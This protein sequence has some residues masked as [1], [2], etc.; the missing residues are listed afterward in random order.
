MDINK[1]LIRGDYIRYLGTSTSQ[2]LIKNK[3][4]RLTCSP[5]RNLVAIINEKGNR[6]VI[7]NKHFKI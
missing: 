5:Y 7:K 1:N 6:M 4:Y 3:K 2:Y